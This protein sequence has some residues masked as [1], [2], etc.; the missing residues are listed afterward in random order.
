MARE[1]SALCLPSGSL[2][3]FCRIKAR[4][5]V[6]LR[7][8]F[9]ALVEGVVD[10]LVVQWQSQGM[11]GD[12]LDRSGIG[13]LARRRIL[14]AAT[15]RDQLRQCG[16]AG[17]ILVSTAEHHRQDRRNVADG[18]A[19]SGSGMQRRLATPGVLDGRSHLQLTYLGPDP[20]GLQEVLQRRARLGSR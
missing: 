10:D 19:A 17:I 18:V 2:A 4:Q 15:F 1:D 7:R 16:I 5:F 9:Q 12:A 6:C 8:E 20:D 11:I 13:G 14:R 3:Q